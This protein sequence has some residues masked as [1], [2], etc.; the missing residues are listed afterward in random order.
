MLYR[1]LYM[2]IPVFP[3]ISVY[4][5]SQNMPKMR[6]DLTQYDDYLNGGKKK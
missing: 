3:D 4:E 1:R 5:H 2:D 6:V